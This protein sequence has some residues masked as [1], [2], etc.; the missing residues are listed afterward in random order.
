M[1]K[2]SPETFACYTGTLRCGHRHKQYGN[3]CAGC[4]D[5]WP[6][7]FHNAQLWTGIGGGQEICG[8]A[9]ALTRLALAGI[10]EVW[11]A[12]CFLKWM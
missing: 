10:G 2:K 7:T 4:G 5:P 1:F 12:R 3:Q 11:D 9:L 8:V 6:V